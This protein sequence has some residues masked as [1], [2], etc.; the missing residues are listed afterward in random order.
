MSDTPRTDAIRSA[1]SDYGYPAVEHMTEHARQLERDL[2]AMRSDV[3]EDCARVC[4][5][6]VQEY[7]EQARAGLAN[8]NVVLGHR[9]LVAEVCGA[10]IRELK[11]VSLP[12]PPAMKP[13]SGQTK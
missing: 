13:V 9:Q 11:Y 5:K 12:A 6:F 1:I 10:H 4:D 7:T 3:I 2:S 8:G